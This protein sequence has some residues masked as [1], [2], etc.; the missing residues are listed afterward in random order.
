VGVRRGVVTMLFDDGRSQNASV[1]NVVTPQPSVTAHAAGAPASCSSANLRVQFVAL[2][3]DFQ[4]VVGQPATVQVKVVDDCG[5]PLAPET[6]ASTPVSASFSKGDPD[7]RLSHEGSGVW[8]G[9]WRPTNQPEGTGTVTVTVRAAYVKLGSQ[10]TM[11]TGTVQ[12]R[13]TMRS[14][15]ANISARINQLQVAVANG[16]V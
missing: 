11:Q 8:A 3:D 9:T 10:Q 13:G 2:R 5:N 7:V 15:T 16:V 14:G 4:V 6:G 1:L 12:L